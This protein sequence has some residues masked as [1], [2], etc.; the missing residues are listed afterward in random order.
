MKKYKEFNGMSF[1]ENTPNDVCR[2]LADACEN[3]YRIRVFY[4][5]PETGKSWNDEFDTIGTVGRS[6]GTIKIPLLIK[7]KRSNGG[8]GI[9]DDKIL[10]IVDLSTKSILYQHQNYKRDTFICLYK[11]VSSDEAIVC[12]NEESNVYAN[13]K[14]MKQAL[15]LCDFMNG[16]KHSK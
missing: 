14:T 9:L 8:G 2:I 10:K 12:I 1:G 11:S 7:T 13:C 6:T 5:D 15:R 16:L 3:K 4:G